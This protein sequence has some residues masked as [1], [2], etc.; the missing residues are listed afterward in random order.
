MKLEILAAESLGVRSLCC[1]VSLPDRC[2]VIDPGIAL[3]YKREGLLPH[4]VQVAVGRQVRQKILDVLETATDIVFSHYH[5]D[6]VP[7]KNANPYQLS[8]HALSD[9]FWNLPCWCKSPND[10]SAEMHK[11]FEDLKENFGANMVVTEGRKEGPLAFSHAVSHGLP[12][13]RMGKVMMTRVREGGETFVHASDI[14]LLNDA[15]VDQV[16]SWQPDIALA[17]GPP[18]YLTRLGENERHISW[19]NALRLAKQVD[20]L[21]IDHH[22]MRSQEGAAWLEELSAS[23]GKKVYCAADFMN[24]SRR[25][26]EADR[27]LLYREMPVPDTWHPDYENG[28]V[29]VDEYLE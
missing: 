14:Q 1:Q 26:L 12:D 7:L 21:I 27:T 4:P 8:F 17:G 18:L 6:H 28:L 23:A 13:S 5:G 29:D 10:L 2:I 20:T 3:G 24:E 9:R 11:R 16:V 25:L 22:L 15:A 19:E